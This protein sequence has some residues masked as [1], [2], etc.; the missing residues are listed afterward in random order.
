MLMEELATVEAPSDAEFW[1]GV[2]VGAGIG[3]A[4]GFIIFC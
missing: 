1:G 4:I 2:A 3:L